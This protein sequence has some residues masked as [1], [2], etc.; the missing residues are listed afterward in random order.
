[1]GAQDFDIDRLFKAPPYETVKA[2]ESWHPGVQP[3]LYEY[4]EWNGRP[5]KA[6]AW[7]GLP[8]LKP[9][10]KCP[11]IVLV[12]GGGGTAFADW[13][14]L[15]TSRGY[16]AIAMD[17]CGGVPCWN[18]SPYCRYLWP[19]HEFS[20]PAGWGDFENVE[21]PVNEQWPYQATSTVIAAH[22]LL[23]SLPEVDASRIGITGI[24]W[25]GILTCMA[26]GLDNRFAFAAPVYGCGFL[27]AMVFTEGMPPR[28]TPEKNAKW[29]SMW[30]PSLYL[31]SA[32]M[33]FLWV[34]GTNDFAFNMESMARS[35]GLVRAG[36]I[37]CVPVCMAHGHGGVGEKPPEILD[38]ANRIT[39]HGESLENPLLSSVGLHGSLASLGFKPGWKSS[40][41]ELNYTLGS[42]VWKDRLWET[43]SASL[44]LASGK[45]SAEIPKG[46][47]A[48]YFNLFS[49][50]G[51][52]YSSRPLIF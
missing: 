26:S 16:A 20:G 28:S 3:L 47:T 45:I 43:A 42:G 11:G 25:G 51:L 4:G 33:P 37:F 49:E 14:R 13:V 17:N 38:F 41:A 48:L 24:S 10:R 34:N 44:D 5:A 21:K 35:A 39:G 46:S 50:A 8:E 40:K 7:L 2:L 18:E 22:S 12:H 32:E 30:D 31:A 27:D 9:G 19:R 36:S 1:M 15:W 52:I 6:F 23:R 29:L